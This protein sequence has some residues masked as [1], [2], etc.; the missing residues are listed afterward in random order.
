MTRSRNNTTSTV[1]RS[2]PRGST[3]SIRAAFIIYK[4]EETGP[5]AVVKWRRAQS[6]KPTTESG[7]SATRIDGRYAH[8]LHP[9]LQ[10]TARPRPR[11]GRGVGDADADFD[12]NRAAAVFRKYWRGPRG[13][14]RYAHFKHPT[15]CSLLITSFASSHLARDGE[16]VRS[17]ESDVRI[18][19]PTVVDNIVIRPIRHTSETESERSFS[20]ASGMASAASWAARRAPAAT[21]R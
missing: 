1:A 4:K 15:S 6:P 2:P 20:D 11:T 8:F 17:I 9:P 10:S 18:S 13:N 12:L 14:W 21:R 3:S 7:R 19:I 16:R 5:E